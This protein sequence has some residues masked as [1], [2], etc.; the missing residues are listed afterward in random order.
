MECVSGAGS[1]GTT[2]NGTTGIIFLHHY[3][4]ESGEIRLEEIP[5]KQRHIFTGGNFQPINFI[6]EVVIKHLEERGK[7]LFDIPKVKNPPRTGIHLSLNMD[8]DHEGMSMEAPTLMP[9]GSPGQMVSRI[10]CKFLKNLHEVV[11]IEF[12]NMAGSA[13]NL[14]VHDETMPYS[15]R[16]QSKRT[17]IIPIY[18]QFSRK[19]LELS[20][21]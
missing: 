20:Y 5:D 14:V 21:D 10:K 9:F 3:F 13:S 7:C 1:T 16:F 4:G 18:S 8:S 19:I 2:V 6:E 15:L 12:Q 11:N 17:Q